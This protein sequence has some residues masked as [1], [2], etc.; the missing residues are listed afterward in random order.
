MMIF[1]NLEGF[2][3]FGIFA[4]LFFKGRIVKSVKLVCVRVLLVFIGH[5]LFSLFLTKPGHFD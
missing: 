5:F 3:A 2:L 1:L 4:F